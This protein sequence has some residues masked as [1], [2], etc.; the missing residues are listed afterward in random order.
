[1]TAIKDDL[2]AH[3]AQETGTTKKEARRAVEAMIEYIIST[4]EDGE[5][6]KLVGFGT[7]EPKP[8]A[9]RIGVNPQTKEPMQIEASIVPKF[10]PGKPYK[11][12]V[13]HEYNK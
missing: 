10:K 11:E 8:H 4:N 9:S 1:M 5:K 6:V 2:V 3:V 13:N 7:F 12:R